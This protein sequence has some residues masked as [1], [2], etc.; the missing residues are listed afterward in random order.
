MRPSRS[1]L[2]VLFIA[3]IIS[4]YVGY[5]AYDRLTGA[6][7]PPPPPRQT[8]L[9]QRGNIAATV[10]ASGSVIS[11]NQPTVTFRSSG[12]VAEVDVTPGAAVKK[13]QVL[14][15][16]DP[17]DLEVALDQAKAN[18]AS[19]QAKLDTIKDGARPEDIAAA[20]AAVAGAQA[21]LS[22]MVS[23]RPES[24]A[25]AQAAV[26]SAQAK[27]DAIMNPYTTADIDAQQAAVA[28]AQ[29]AVQTAQT[30]LYNLQNPDPTQV[31]NA[32]IE[33]DRSK[34]ALNQQYINRDLTCGQRG[35]A[36]AEC[37]AAGASAAASEAAVQTAQSNLTKLL[38]GPNQADLA[39]SQAAAQSAQTQLASAQQKLAEMKAGPKDTDVAQ[40]Q[41]ALQQAQQ[42][43]ALQTNP[44]SPQD[45]AQ[46]QAT[47]QQ[48]QQ[49]LSLKANPYTVRD[50]QTAQAAVDQAQANV[51]QAQYNL[52]NSVLTSP[53]DGMVSTVGYSVG[54]Q[55]S[56]GGTVGAP[57]IVLVDTQRVR[58]D[59]NVD[60][61]D[62]A[63]VSIG[64]RATITFDALSGVQ[65]Q[66][67]VTAVSPNAQV[68][69]GVVTF[70]A[71]V[72][73]ETGQD[74]YKVGMSGTA[75]IVVAQ[76]NNVL[77]VPN[78]AVRTVGR[79]RVVDVLETGSDKPVTKQVTIGMSNDTQTEIT[80]GLNQGDVVIIQTTTTT[81]PRV[82]GG[83]GGP[84]GGP[85]GVLVR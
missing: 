26:D 34:N 45:I 5:Q 65:F 61:T 80:S 81:A 68:N 12:K 79:N 73:L 25:N 6:N 43:L 30:N 1:Q 4:A 56:S 78:R 40:A 72:V 47:V 51:R 13:G 7:A 18:L 27:L 9:V 54:A 28:Q 23:G 50:L 38:A 70:P 17:V 75:S 39:Q 31:R 14:A 3:G 71:S 15:K 22:S 57:G 85:G 77:V 66:G 33:L 49:Q 62:V 48:A 2:V 11:Q 29:S 60:E 82:G 74:G 69:S 84:G 37:K 58:L 20:E 64:Q 42:Q 16:L 8:A 44:S 41:A 63:K 53:F 59:V 19:A 36:S 35:K 52:D 76:R 10:S 21:K 46:Q 32:Q 83:I 67:T 55:S 24:I